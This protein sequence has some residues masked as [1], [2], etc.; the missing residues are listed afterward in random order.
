MMRPT[1]S[2]ELGLDSRRSSGKRALTA[3]MELFTVPLK[4]LMLIFLS[5]VMK[6]ARAGGSLGH[7]S[8]SFATSVNSTNCR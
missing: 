1:R 2:L 7:D 3:T 5:R 8:M 4:F 6:L